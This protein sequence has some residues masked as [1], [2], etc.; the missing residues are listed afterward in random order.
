MRCLFTFLQGYT[1]AFLCGRCCLYFI[2]IGF[3]TRNWRLVMYHG[4]R[5]CYRLHK[6]FREQYI[7]VSNFINSEFHFYVFEVPSVAMDNGSR[8][9]ADDC[10]LDIKMASR[11]LLLSV[12]KL[13]HFSPQTSR[14]VT[15][16]TSYTLSNSP[17][18][19]LGI[20]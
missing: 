2:I 9:A 17:T 6:W 12:K 10:C 20:L 19:K 1:H 7:L 4:W 15:F 14:I 8:L 16:S 11:A 18:Y 5:Y 13:R 3:W